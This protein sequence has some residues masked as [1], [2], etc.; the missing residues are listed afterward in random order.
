[1]LE[2]EHK[3]ILTPE[4]YRC[5][6]EHL[7]SGAPSSVQTNY[8]YDTDDMKMNSRKT[9][10][11]IREKNRIY[12]AVI[13]EHLPTVGLSKETV[14][15]TGESR[16]ASVFEHMGLKS[17]GSL[18]T[19]RT[20]LHSDDYIKAMI[21]KNIYLGCTD[22][23]LEVEYRP[24]CEEPAALY[25]QTAYELCLSNLGNPSTA[26]FFERARSAKSKSERFFERKEYL[27]E[28]LNY[29]YI[30]VTGRPE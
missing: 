29:K 23:E 7:A 6:F 24:G 8:Y 19:E 2:Y 10:C 18:R 9:T 14:I 13:K 17:Q 26:S 28:K 16:D 27:I 15:C 5:I 4:E 30:Q 12:T 22:Y 1:M 25:M 3:V 21:D 11:R 20:V